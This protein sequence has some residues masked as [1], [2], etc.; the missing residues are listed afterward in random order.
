MSKI[1]LVLAGG[2]LGALLRYSVTLIPFREASGGFP[3]GTLIV[4]I[5]GS[6]IAGFVWAYL[7]QSTGTGRMYAFLVIGMMGAFTTF[8][9]YSIESIRLFES[10]SVNLAVINVLL[11]NVGAILFAFVGISLA[12]WIFHQVV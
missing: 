2:A 6:F 3:V 10:G 11:N 12:K 8:S 7:N 9:A 4:N 1:I 5:V